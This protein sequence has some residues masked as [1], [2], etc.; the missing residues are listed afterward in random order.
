MTY[1][2]LTR[3]QLLKQLDEIREEKAAATQRVL[4]LEAELNQKRNKTTISVE[5][6][7]G[8]T[9]LVVRA[10]E[11]STISNVRVDRNLEPKIAHNPKSWM[12]IGAWA[13]LAMIALP[14][15]LG[16][17]YVLT[18]LAGLVHPIT[19]LFIFALVFL[20]VSIGIMFYEENRR[21]K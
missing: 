1:R 17:V 16:G 8:R 9:N 3:E 15:L 19:L 18:G 7:D 14:S 10:T 4:D 2:E 21:I 11:G 6:E 5:D 12:K 13:I 20:A